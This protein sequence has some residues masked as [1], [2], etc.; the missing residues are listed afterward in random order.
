MEFEREEAIQP[1][2]NE[3]FE[4]YYL[5]SYPKHITHAFPNNFLITHSGIALRSAS[6]EQ[7]IVLEYHPVNETLCFLPHITK[8]A[9]EGASLGIIW[10]QSASIS[11]M[12]HIDEDYWD[13]TIYLTRINNVVYR[14]YLDWVDDYLFSHPLFQPYSVCLS[15]REGGC[16]FPK[17]TWDTFVSDS[18]EK[19]S[20]FAVTI[21]PITPLYE[22]DWIFH[23]QHPPERVLLRS[24]PSVIPYFNQLLS[25]LRG[26]CSSLPPTLTL[27]YLTFSARSSQEPF[28]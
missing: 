23:S 12:K 19:L 17:Q 9:P 28:R 24:D 4:L 27:P 1:H 16:P 13:K 21:N 5:Q 10:D 7:V 6:T 22:L 11:M 20:E 8:P 15:S 2:D 25:C 14:Q 3:Y 18:F 26:G